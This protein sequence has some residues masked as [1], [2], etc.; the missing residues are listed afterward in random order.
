LSILNPLFFYP[1]LSSKV[2]FRKGSILREGAILSRWLIKKKRKR[3]IWKQFQGVAIER[4]GVAVG[5]M[6]WSF[7]VPFLVIRA[8]SDSAGEGAAS[9]FDKFLEESSWKSVQLVEKIL[10]KL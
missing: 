5:K 6:C 1:P 10:Q 9:D 2:W 3:K 8:I 4:E 7:K